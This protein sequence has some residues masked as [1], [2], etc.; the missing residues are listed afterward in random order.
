MATSSCAICGK[1][2]EAKTA[3][4]KTCSDLC[5]KKLSLN[6]G[7]GVVQENEDRTELLL[8]T[9]K[10]AEPEELERLAKA[11]HPL[12][13]DDVANEPLSLRLQYGPTT[14]LSTLFKLRGLPPHAALLEFLDD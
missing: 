13:L 4:K 2:F 6:G 7:Q 11:I 9:M 12:E 14:D 3:R 5:R 1:W 8:S 10:T